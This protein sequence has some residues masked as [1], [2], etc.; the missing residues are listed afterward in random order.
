MRLF[1]PAPTDFAKSASMSSNSAL[2]MALEM[3]HTVAPV[4]GS[5]KPV[6]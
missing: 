5:T 4:A 3:F 6:T 1:S 2:L